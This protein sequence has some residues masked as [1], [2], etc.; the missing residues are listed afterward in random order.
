MATGG[1][2]SDLVVQ[3]AHRRCY[4]GF[5]NNRGTEDRPVFEI[6]DREPTFSHLEALY[7]HGNGS[8]SLLHSN[9]LRIHGHSAERVS[10]CLTTA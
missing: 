5:Q 3:H 8:T 6:H 7:R 2:V 9:D 10:S 4:F 1:P